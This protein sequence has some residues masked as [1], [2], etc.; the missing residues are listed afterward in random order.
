MMK[1]RHTKISLIL[2]LLAV[3]LIASLTCVACASSAYAI[4]LDRTS[5]TLEK[6]ES[7]ELEYQLTKNGEADTQTEVVVSVKGYS[8]TYTK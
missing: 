8:L 4:K 1:K 2:L 3:M 7:A 6:G 5:V